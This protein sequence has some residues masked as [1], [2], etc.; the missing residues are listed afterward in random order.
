[1]DKFIRN[2]NQLY[3]LREL[4]ILVSGEFILTK[5]ECYRPRVRTERVK[6]LVN[7]AEVDE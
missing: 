3:A 1:V 7:K 4:L 2:I 6:A 5:N